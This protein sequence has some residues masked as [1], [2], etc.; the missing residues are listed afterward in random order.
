MACDVIRAIL[1]MKFQSIVAIFAK[2]F[3][4]WM[5]KSDHDVE[6][7]ASA[8]VSITFVFFSI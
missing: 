8:I 5:L 3:G 4:H 2:P 1:L 6:Q 7:F